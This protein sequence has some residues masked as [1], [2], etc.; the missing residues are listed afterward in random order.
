MTHPDLRN[1]AADLWKE[2]L[3]AEGESRCLGLFK[4]DVQT[5][6]TFGWAGRSKAPRGLEPDFPLCEWAFVP[7]SDL[8]LAVAEGIVGITSEGIF[9]DNF[10]GHQRF[11]LE[12]LYEKVGRNIKP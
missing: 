8:L 11:T 5:P 4:A 9:A 2:V 3:L 6:Q 10:P 7:M 12:E 1:L